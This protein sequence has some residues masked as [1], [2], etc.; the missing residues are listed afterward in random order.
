M[1]ESVISIDHEDAPWLVLRSGREG[2]ATCSPYFSFARDASRAYVCHEFGATPAKRW[3][4]H[5]IEDSTYSLYM[6]IP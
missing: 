6:H 2:A 5:V 1:V 4:E 3:K